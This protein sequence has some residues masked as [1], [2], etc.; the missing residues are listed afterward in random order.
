MYASLTNAY[1]ATCVIYLQGRFVTLCNDNSIH[2]WQLET[3]DG[4]SVLEEVRGLTFDAR[5]INSGNL[6]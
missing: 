3:Q 1:D 4:S 5:L 2:L 6:H